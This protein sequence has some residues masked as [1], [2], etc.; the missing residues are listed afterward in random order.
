MNIGIPL[1]YLANNLEAFSSALNDDALNTCL[2]ELRAANG[3]DAQALANCRLAE[4]L[5][6]ADRHEAALECCRRAMPGAADDAAMLQICAWVFSNCAC[7]AEAADAYCRLL[8]L[9]PAWV[10]NHRHASGALAASGRLDA[11]LDHA[12]AASDGAPHNAEFAL[13]AGSLLRHAGR[14]EEAGHYLDRALSQEPGNARALCDFAAVQLALGR[15]E[16]AAALAAQAA[17]LATTDAHL[18]SDAAEM[19]LQCG[20][21]KAAAELLRNAAAIGGDA[22]L[23]R[24]LSAAE[25]VEGDLGAALAAAVRAVA[26]APDNA[27]YH[28]H[29]ALLLA[30][31]SDLPAATEAVARAAA[32][33][34]ASRD[35]KRVQ[36]ELLQAAG[37]VS[38]ATAVGGELLHR[39]PDDRPAAAA[40]L[41]LLTRRLDTIDGEYTVLHDGAA[42]AARPPPPPPGLLVRLRAQRRII[43][44]LIIRESR[45]RF[46]EHKLGYGWALIEP[47]LHIA[48][49]SATFA[50]LMHGR[51]PIGS[52][53]FIFYYT[54]LIRY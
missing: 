34:P 20:R 15:A 3:G 17:A 31:L 19:L 48:L 10:E 22:R 50:V 2:L 36:L 51:P 14:H 44:A 39:F 24:V 27:E 41:H 54:G 23:W 11:A 45:T 8:L 33:D 49:L 40:M 4:A 28:L 35:L 12:I 43:G 9:R 21:A 26:E 16:D 37:L 42:R 52:H 46:A 38:E 5:L 53:F 13:H 30:R 25:M 1:P 6:H 18:A 29:H 47:I 7:H 32:L